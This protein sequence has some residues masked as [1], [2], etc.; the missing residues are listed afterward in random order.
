MITGPEVAATVGGALGVAVIGGLTGL[1]A[2]R[3]LRNR[4]TVVVLGVVAVVAAIVV[5]ASVIITGSLMIDSPRIL[6][7]LVAAVVASACMGL[8]LAGF[9]GQHRLAL[10]H[11]RESALE[12][13]RRDL[14]AWVSH[15][16]RSPLAA[17]RAMAEALLDDVVTDPDTVARYHRQILDETMHLS[18]LVDDLFLL[19]RIAAGALRLDRRP[20]DAT[21]AA[22]RAVAASGPSAQAKG[23]AIDVTGPADPVV[24]DADPEQLSR[25]LRNLVTNAVQYSRAGT[26]VSVSVARIGHGR[27]GEALVAVRD[28]CGAIDGPIE[29]LFEVGYRAESS[30][31]RAEADGETG[32]AGLGL[33]IARG[34]TEA[35][36]GI[37]MAHQDIGGCRFELRLPVA[38]DTGN[39]H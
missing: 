23:I 21:E 25:A 22:R 1:L 37:L 32:G 39:S 2:L 5:V 12:A 9:L 3:F 4:P 26:A 11:E 36:G 10:M 31:P 16:L 18:R 20:I 13:S 24:V 15:D 17:L 35:H 28:G 29:R 30:R 27:R 7:T 8:V 34:I 6:A 33:A 38:T 14:V 19:S